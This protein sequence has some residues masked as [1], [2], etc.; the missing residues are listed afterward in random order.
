MNMKTKTKKYF[1]FLLTLL[2]TLLIVLGTRFL[3][4]TK[5]VAEVGV[6]QSNATISTKYNLSSTL[7]IPTGNI[8]YEENTYEADSYYLKKPNGVIN[9]GRI[10]TLDELGNYT[11]IYSAKR[12]NLLLTAEQDFSVYQSVYGVSSQDSSVNYSERLTRDKVSGIQV[13]LSEGD[14]FNFNE[15][16]NL[17]GMDEFISFYPY[18]TYKSDV[19][20]V[21]RPNGG[22]TYDISAQKYIV[23][24]I[25]CYDLTNYFEIELAIVAS[26]QNSIP[27]SNATYFRAGV[28]TQTKAAMQTVREDKKISSPQREIYAEGVRYEVFYGDNYGVAGK[29]GTA[30]TIPA[31]SLKYEANT[32]RVYFNYG[33]DWKLIND[34]DNADVNSGQLFTGF[35]TGEVYLSVYAENYV[36]ATTEFEISKIGNYENEQLNC[37]GDYVDLFAPELVVNAPFDLTK[38]CYAAKGETLTVFDAYATDVNLVGSVKTKVFYEYNSDKP[39]QI[40]LRDDKFT[41]TRTGDYTIVY[42]ASDTYGNI[43]IKTVTLTVINVDKAIFFETDSV[44]SLVAGEVCVLPEYTFSSINDEEIDISIFATFEGNEDNKT[45]IDKNTREFFV[46]NVGEYEICYIVKGILTQIE[47]SYK[48]NSVSEGNI[49][50]DISNA[51]L[52][53]YLIKNA[54]YT[55]DAVKAYK[56]E[57]KTPIEVDCQY[58]VSED[59]K[60]EK[61]IDYSNYKVEASSTVR[62]KYISGDTVVYSPTIHVVDVGFGNNLSVKDYFVGDMTKESKS[63][64]IV[65]SPNATSGSVSA[66][67]INVLSLNAFSIA[68]KVPTD[69]DNFSSFNVVLSDIYDKNIV[70]TLSFGKTQDGNMTLCANNGVPVDMGTPFVYNRYVTLNY[71]GSN[72]KFSVTGGPT[73]DCPV[74]FTT[75]KIAMQI[76]FDDIAGESAVELNSLSSQRLSKA[77]KDGVAPSLKYNDVE[78]GERDLNSVV[79]VFAPIVGDVLS[80]YLKKNLSVKVFLP[81]GDFATSIDNVLLDG[82]CAA[83]RDYQFQLSEYGMYKVEY[84]YVDQTNNATQEG[85]A[86]YVSDRTS[87]TITIANGYNENTLLGVKLGAVVK[88]ADYTISDD[89]GSE[90]LLSWVLVISPINEMILT[91]AGKELEFDKKGRWKICYYCQDSE[92]NA[93]MRYYYVQVK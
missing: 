92:G 16:I 2:S 83:D 91:E 3:S 61:Q 57:A 71:D 84:T 46:E 24:V 11:I 90:G 6:L 87:P 39:T 85:F 27:Y 66:D 59:G 88:I 44:P 63:A 25:D 58:Y 51:Y 34:L 15:P 8:L 37:D 89:F 29:W 81:N 67:Y 19:I 32:N 60:D 40:Y 45:I 56:Y 78:K 28:G 82:T 50:I 20:T 7:E 22:Y 14:K 30:E 52:P 70:C 41:P 42:T 62:F 53:N 55:F 31:C 54:E 93:T 1:V 73:I 86:I 80:P 74:I 36:R 21:D 76:R 18:A 49:C 35:K 26:N 43:A 48:V 12:D 38:K 79:S 69:K 13:S 5:V 68:L 9:Q 23:R 65:F 10:H 77:T 64:S 72:Q 17:Q 4:E 47:Y 33:S 75:D